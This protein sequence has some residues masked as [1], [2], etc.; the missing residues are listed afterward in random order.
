LAEAGKL[1][2]LKDIGKRFSS[3]YVAISLVLSGAWAQAGNVMA[4]I[5]VLA[6][7]FFLSK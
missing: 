6:Y 3:E 4:K 5:S 2:N 1:V 7:F